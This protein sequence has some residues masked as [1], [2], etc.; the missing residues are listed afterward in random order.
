MA[1]S[2]LQQ[3]VKRIQPV[4]S[5]RKCSYPLLKCRVERMRQRIPFYPTPNL[6]SSD[7]PLLPQLA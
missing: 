7:R 4:K 5:D 3:D 2:Q 6:P 1:Q